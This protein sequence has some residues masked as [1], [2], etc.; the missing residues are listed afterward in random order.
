MFMNEVDGTKFRAV[1]SKSN[2]YNAEVLEKKLKRI[3]ENI[4]EY[5]SQMDKNDEA[6]PDP[7][8]PEQIKKPPYRN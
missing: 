5:L 8:S 2:T 1:N 7:L 3:D 4:A 6:E